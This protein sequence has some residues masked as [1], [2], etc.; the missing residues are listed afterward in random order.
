MSNERCALDITNELNELR[1]KTRY[2]NPEN[3]TEIL[4]AISTSP[5]PSLIDLMKIR[6][7]MW[8]DYVK[9]LL[10]LLE[11]LKNRLS[12]NFA[13]CK[14]ISEKF[15]AFTTDYN[16]LSENFQKSKNNLNLLNNKI[17][18]DTKN[19]FNEVWKYYNGIDENVFIRDGKHQFLKTFFQVS[20]IATAVYWILYGYTQFTFLTYSF[21]LWLGLLAIIFIGLQWYLRRGIEYREE[22]TNQ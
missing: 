7:T 12:W 4:D 13:D 5:L 8:L 22:D 15:G 16:D 2:A 3:E 21:I 1:K 9:L 14:G 19:L 10:D 17:L 18:T 11:T 6:I 20:T